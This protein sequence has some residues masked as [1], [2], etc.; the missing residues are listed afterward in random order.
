MRHLRRFY[1]FLVLFT[2]I[3]VAFSPRD[4]KSTEVQIGNKGQEK[5]FT[6]KSIKFPEWYERRT[7][8]IDIEFTEEPFLSNLKS[9]LK[10]Q[11]N[12]YIDWYRVRRMRENVYRIYGNFSTGKTY[13][14]SIGEIKSKAGNSYVQTVKSFQFPD[15]PPKIKLAGT[16]SVVER[17]SRQLFHTH[18]I[19]VDEL[20]VKSASVPPAAIPVIRLMNTAELKKAVNGSLLDASKK[21]GTTYASFERDVADDS[22]FRVLTGKS[23]YESK[24][25]FTHVGKNKEKEFSAPMNF[26]EN[27]NKGE[28]LVAVVSNN[29]KDESAKSDA[30]LLRVTDLSITYKASPKSLLVWLTSLNSGKPVADTRVF[31]VTRQRGY[32]F[33]GKTNDDGVVLAKEEKLFKNIDYADEASFVTGK[34]RTIKESKLAFGEVQ[35]IIAVT[36][37]DVSYIAFDE[38]LIKPA[39]IKTGKATLKKNDYYKGQVFTERG[40][41]R[42]GEKVHFKGTVRYYK[43]G[44]MAL[45]EAKECRVLIFN[46]KGVKIYEEKKSFSDYGTISDEVL[47][48]KHYP[49]GLYKLHVKPLTGNDDYARVTFQ[50]QEFRPPRH[51]VDVTYKTESKEN[52]DYIGIKRDDLF[53]VGT[54]EGKYYSGGP[55]QNGKVQWKV[56][57]SSSDYKVEDYDAYTFSHPLI[58]TR[59]LVETG[60]SML[61]DQGKIGVRI[62]INQ[63]V[64]AG[65][66]G[67]EIV[68]TVV[69]IDGRPATGKSLYQHEPDFL[70]GISNHPAKVSIN[71]K[72]HLNIVVLDK[73]K[74][75]I[76][77]GKL[78]VEVMNEGY[79]YVRKTSITG[80]VY[81]SRKKTWRKEFSTSVP[82]IKGDAEF[83][84]DFYR[85]G[86]FLVRFTYSDEDGHIFNSGVRY[87]VLG[88]GY[89]G[90]YYYD[91][92][93]Q[94]KS[95]RETQDRKIFLQTERA[96]YQVGDEINL[97]ANSNQRLTSVLMTLERDGIIEYKVINGDNL[98]ELTLEA[99]DEYSP[100]VYLSL[101]GT[102]GRGEFP[103]YGTEVDREAPNYAYGYANIVINKDSSDLDV[104]IGDESVELKYEPGDEVT[105]DLVAQDSKGNGI[106]CELA[107]CVVDEGVLALTR[108]MTPSLAALT[109]FVYPLGVETHDMRDF[110]MLQ[111]PFALLFNEPLTGG[112]GKALGK[113]KDPVTAKIRKDFNPLAYFNPSVITDANGKASVTFT[114]PDTM[115]SY[116]VYTVACDKGSSFDSS[117]R[118]LRVTK[119]FYIE[120]G[121]PRFMTRGDR[122]KVLVSVFNKTKKS[123]TASFSAESNDNVEITSHKEA[124]P[125]KEFERAAIPIE[126]YA[127]RP[128]LS[129][130]TFTGGFDGKK[131]IIQLK[132]PINLGYPSDTKIFYG[133]L[134]NRN[135]IDTELKNILAPLASE[136][137]GPGEVTALMTFSD[138][139]FIKLSQGLKYLLQY[140]YGCI[141]QTSSR[142]LA[143]AGL[144]TAL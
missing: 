35:L 67:L 126:L 135:S 47:L 44:T 12:V 115:T 88:P 122:S 65:N 20:L 4:A 14:I 49:L 110:L 26:R 120:P 30:R 114:L 132:M 22:D 108:F 90:Y 54:I 45:P 70:V 57:Y 85:G 79:S 80:R 75:K 99:K 112:D 66:Y 7:G 71:E 127:R 123:G 31:A 124:Y 40:I 50:V 94:N 64:L 33:L 60:E 102:K 53:L 32:F 3:S 28:T 91:Y 58:T 92:N 23:S 106:V 37:D 95:D 43:D 1:I 138:S 81:W 76:K 52:K 9:Y 48:K 104:V 51:F 131:D 107:V 46:S 96:S 93:A 39:N 98:A 19:N 87:E 121:I 74:N 109:R 111:T 55:V 84:F 117:E 136:D 34:P 128:G 59:E 5:K 129:E 139:P 100:N 27:A 118:S 24:L 41:Y 11:P 77:S 21:L 82:I 137:I 140:P 38:G 10:I 113:K 13:F 103:V 62:P 125:L 36:D 142:V 56:Y 15:E 25:F 133:N 63:E 83:D 73:K 97:F 16:E 134:N 141:E 18:L 78:S 8:S 42:P 29:R 2:F 86:V 6:I 72:Q 143:L 105:I 89:Y 116:R 17:Y 144:H 101:L 69:D 61:D 119:D 130:M 68:A